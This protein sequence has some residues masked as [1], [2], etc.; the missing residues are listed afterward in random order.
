MLAA[1]F[2]GVY[3]DFEY[4]DVITGSSRTVLLFTARVGE[5]QMEGVQVLGFDADDL[6]NELVVMVRPAASASALGRAIMAAMGI[7][8]PAEIGP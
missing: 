5:H 6:V 1:A 4:Q 2:A 7:E 3:E 8:S